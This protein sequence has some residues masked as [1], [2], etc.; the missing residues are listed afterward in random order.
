MNTTLGCLALAGVACA[1]AAD[2]SQYHLLNPTPR[3]LMRE[4]STDR[5][6]KTESPYTVDAGHVQ[7]EMDVLNYSYDRYNGL[8]GD[9][10]IEQVAIA[11]IN[12]KIGLC[13][14][15][16]LQLVVESYNSIRVHNRSTGA[17]IENRGFGDVIPRLKVN[18]WGNDSGSTAFALMPWL[19]LPTNQ[20]DL[21]NHSV[22]GGIIAPLAVALPYE[23]G[24]GLMP[25][26]DFIR[27]DSGSGHHPE[28]VNSITLN[29]D[30][31]GDLSGFV[32]FYSSVSTESDSD[33]VGTFDVG[34]TYLLTEDIQLDA[35]VFLGLTRAAEDVN[36]F[37]GVSWR[38]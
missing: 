30:L 6:D 23:F 31:V 18:L 19:K 16:D 13:N 15:A 14:R 9:T 8:P 25:Q 26:V 27:D 7:I 2:K 33:W 37:F 35:G 34:L 5:P 29:H 1:N 28:F 11:P 3:E 22:E 32:E 4:F 12:F 20:D 21:G 24:L 38:F 17:V 36:P 10:R